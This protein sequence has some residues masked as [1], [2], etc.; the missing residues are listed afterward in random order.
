MIRCDA[1]G[2]PKVV[3]L[4]EYYSGAYHFK[5]FNGAEVSVFIDEEDIPKEANPWDDVAM[6]LAEQR[7]LSAISLPGVANK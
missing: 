4:L 7:L 2:I 6:H 1:D 5:L 3:K